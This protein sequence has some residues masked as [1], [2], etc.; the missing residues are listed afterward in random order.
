MGV[1]GKQVVFA[2]DQLQ[3]KGDQLL[4]ASD[5]TRLQLESSMKFEESKFRAFELQCEYA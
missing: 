1:S 2:I 3:P 4:L 5:L